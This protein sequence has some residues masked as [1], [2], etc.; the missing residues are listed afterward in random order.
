M[1]SHSTNEGTSSVRTHVVMI[2]NVY[3]PVIG[4]ISTF[5]KDLKIG[6]EN[7]GVSVDLAVFPASLGRLPAPIRKASYVWFMAR[8]LAKACYMKLRGVSPVIVSHSASFCLMSAVFATRVLKCKSMH[9]FH[10]PITSKSWYLTRF[11]PYLDA[12][13]YVSNATRKL[14]QGHGVPVHTNEFIVPGGIDI[15]QFP[16]PDFEKKHQ[17]KV[18]RILFVGRVCEEKGVREVM[19]AVKIVKHEV[20]L[21]IVG[22]TQNSQ[23]DA[24]LEDLEK[25]LENSLLLKRR[26]RFHGAL[27]GA[28]LIE[29]YRAA[30]LFVCP[31][32][33]EEPAPMVIAEAQASGLPVLAF[34]TGGLSERI[35]DGID[36]WLVPKGDVKA[37]ATAIERLV[38]NP[39]EIF[40]AGR[41]ARAK[42]EKEFDRSLM[43]VKV[44][45][46]VDSI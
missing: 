23:Q 18:I 5:V 29:E 45:N 44:L 43:A 10:S 12:V 19:Q 35:N 37:L 38:Q 7:K 27:S 26:V 46:I 24:Y 17:E 16:E 2:T 15:S 28:P 1:S 41:R 14:Y 39:D 20:H 36:G 9:I 3:F 13:A 40:S 34:N 6:L 4:G 31:S 33:W 8:V 11:S 25:E 21:D 42:A 32:I 22:N 30:S